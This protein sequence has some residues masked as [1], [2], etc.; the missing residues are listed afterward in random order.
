M[1]VEE[2]VTSESTELEQALYQTDW[3][4]PTPLLI[5]KDAQTNIGICKRC[6]K[7]A[8]VSTYTA[9]GGTDASYP[10]VSLCAECA[11]WFEVLE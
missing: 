6:K 8:K 5:S 7:Q 2:E 4:D 10:P 1:A 11:E 9:K 3:W